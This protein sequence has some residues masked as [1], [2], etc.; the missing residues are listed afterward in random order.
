MK[1]SDGKDFY[2]LPML[3]RQYS[4]RER[5]RIRAKER[6]ILCGTSENEVKPKSSDKISN[7]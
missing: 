5:A 1:L 7:N 4:A 3:P 2:L 6:I